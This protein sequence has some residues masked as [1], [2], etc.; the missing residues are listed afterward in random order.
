MIRIVE[1]EHWDD[2]GLPVVIVHGKTRI[3]GNRPNAVVHEELVYIEGAYSTI[4]DVISADK[5]WSHK[6]ETKVE[7]KR[8]FPG[9][10]NEKLYVEEK[11]WVGR[12]L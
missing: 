5:T 3:D 1:Y 7:L 12:K 11:G 6:T 4:G 8:V 10:K 2:L 9:T